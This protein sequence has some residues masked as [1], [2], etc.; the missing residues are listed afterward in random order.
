MAVAPPGR[1]L[2]A[3]RCRFLLDCTWKAYW[4]DAGD[5]RGSWGSS[6]HVLVE[7]HNCISVMRSVYTHSVMS[8][9]GRNTER[10]LHETCLTLQMDPI[11]FWSAKYTEVQW[12]NVINYYRVLKPCL[13]TRQMDGSTSIPKVPIIFSALLNMTRGSFMFA[14]TSPCY[15]ATNSTFKTRCPHIGVRTSVFPSR[16]QYSSV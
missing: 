14:W 3:L 9:K 10:E 5:I 4:W 13:G 7:K 11:H 1:P 16:I 12:L 15:H 2:S 8:Q 6:S